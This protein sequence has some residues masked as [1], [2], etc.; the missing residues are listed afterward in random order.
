MREHLLLDIVPRVVL[1]SR[2]LQGALWEVGIQS[3]FYLEGTS[4]IFLLEGPTVQSGLLT[5]GI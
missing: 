5:T 1:Q 3:L 4:P 2:S